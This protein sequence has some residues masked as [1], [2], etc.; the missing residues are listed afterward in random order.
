SCDDGNDCT[1]DTCSPSTGC[2]HTNNKAACSDGNACTPNDTCSAGRCVG[3]PAPNCD[4]GHGST[5]DSRKTSSGCA[6]A[7]NPRPCTDGNACTTS[8]ACRGGR[9][10][11]GAGP[12]CDDGN[13]CTDDTCSPSTGC[14]HT[15]NTAP[16]NDGNACTTNDA[17]SGGRCVG[18]PAPNCNDGNGCT[19]DGCDLATGCVHTNNTAPC[20]DGNAWTTNDACSG[21]APATVPPCAIM[22]PF[23]SSDPRTSVVFNESE[24]LRTFSPTGAVTATP[25]L[26]IKLWYN[27]EHALTLGVRRVSVKTKTGTAVTDY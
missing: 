23:A 25:G 10:V 11:G 26:T 9:C 16:C 6:H 2:A 21:G 15:N 27:D 17:C 14:A 13:A 24:V 22:Y 19:D 12:N 18:G 7:T 20:N 8:G 3:G 1:D 4:D 5:D